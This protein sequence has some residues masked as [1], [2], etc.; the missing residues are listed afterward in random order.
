MEQAIEVKGQ[1]AEEAVVAEGKI[2]ELSLDML[3]LVGGGV[4]ETRLH[5]PTGGGL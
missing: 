2:R 1:R 3:P 5:H 4:M